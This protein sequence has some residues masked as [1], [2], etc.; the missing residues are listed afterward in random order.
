MVLRP[1]RTVAARWSVAPLL[2]STAAWSGPAPLVLRPR[3]MVA[4]RWSVASS[5]L[6]GQ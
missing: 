5:G 2:L 1:R 3:W 4:A 6:R